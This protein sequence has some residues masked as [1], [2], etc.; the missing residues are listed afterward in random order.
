M[1]PPPCGALAPSVKHGGCRGIYNIYIHGILFHVEHRHTNWSNAMPFVPVPNT[2]EVEVIYEMDNQI[3]ENTLYYERTTSVDL[4]SINDLLTAI[5]TTIQASLL[6]F[7][8]NTIKLIRL[9]G[10]LLDAAD[11][12]AAVLAVSPPVAGGAAGEAAPN[13]VSITMSLRTANRGRS[14]RGRNYIPGIPRDLIDENEVGSGSVA[15]YEDAYSALM[16]AGADFGFQQVVV[17]RYSGFTIVD[18]KKKPTPRTTGIT[19]PVTSAFVVDSTVDSQR[20]RL[21]GRGR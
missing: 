20:R 3:V 11:S 13:N 6:P 1:R 18:G 2:V 9:V 10:T 17:S 5:N 16:D 12:L 4:E 8:G 15:A 19:T 21:P 7:L 14:F